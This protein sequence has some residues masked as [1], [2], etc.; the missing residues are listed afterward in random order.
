MGRSIHKLTKLAVE[1]ARR[2]GLY[3]DGGGLYLQV[4]KR[5][6]RSWVL[7]FKRAGQSR[8]MGLGPLHVIDLKEAR[9]R[10]REARRLIDAGLDPIG[11]RRTQAARAAARQ[12]IFD[13][14]TDD[15]IKAHSAGWRSEKHRSQWR[16]T[17]ATY[18]SPVFGSQLVSDVDTAVIVRMLQ[19]LWTT[20]TETASRLR[21]RVEKVL[22][23]CRVRGYREGENPARWKGCLSELLPAKG[24]VHQVKHH[25]ALAYGEVPAFVQELR[26]EASVAARALEFLILTSTRTGDLIGQGREDAPPMLWGHVNL[27]QRLWTIPRTKNSSEHRVPLSHAAVAVLEQ[28]KPLRDASDIVFPGSKQNRP[29]SENAML[30]TI[31]RMGRTEATPHGMRSCFK[32]WA[33]ECTSYPRE[34]VEACLS[35]VISDELEAAYRRTDFFD[36][37]RKLMAQWGSY[38]NT[39]QR[40]ARSVIRLRK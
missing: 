3:N 2:R 38:V 7:R 12:M 37:R 15:Y 8:Y 34:I 11:R 23:W 24:K 4:T 26:R 20:K 31:K 27:N 36:K 22:D 17:L 40:D 1:R 5:G 13:A 18:A 39:P 33:S 25:G 6:T 10:A 14:A 19:S 30:V 16:N 21:G 32:T 28:M 35:H 9:E 29:M